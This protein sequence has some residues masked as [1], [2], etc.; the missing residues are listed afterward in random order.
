MANNGMIENNRTE[1]KKKKGV[2]K[3]GKVDSPRA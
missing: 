1:Q 3:V 2:E